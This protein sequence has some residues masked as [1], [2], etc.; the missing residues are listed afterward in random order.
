MRGRSNHGRWPELAGYPVKTRE[1]I[2]RRAVGGGLADGAAR[3]VALGMMACVTFAL[4]FGFSMLVCGI[5]FSAWVA[6]ERSSW[7]SAF[8]VL[9]CL[10]L[11][12]CIVGAIYVPMAVVRG[13]Q[14]SWT[15][16]RLQA[17]LASDLCAGCE[18][19]KP[20]VADGRSVTCPEC[21][22]IYPGISSSPDVSFRSEGGHA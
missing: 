13:M 7:G 11:L 2:L 6:M 1:A 14:D 20:V 18:Y 16:E 5:A 22:L 4:W 19:P 21:G 10:L 17:C 12:A 3:R 9:A 15:R 8:G